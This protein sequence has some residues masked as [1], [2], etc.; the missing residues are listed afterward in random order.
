MKTA[1]CP[2]SVRLAVA[3]DALND[4]GHF[5]RSAE[6]YAAACAAAAQ[7]LVSE[8]C[9]IVTFLR[10]WQARSIVCHGAVPTLS[11]AERNQALQDSRELLPPCISTLVRCKEAGTLLPGSCRAAEMAWS[12]AFHQHLPLCDISIAEAHARADAFAVMIGYE[13]YL[14]AASTSLDAMLVHTK[15]PQQMLFASFV[16]SALDLLASQP[17]QPAV[18][19]MG[20]V[21][22]NHE[23]T[24]A[25]NV[26]R[27]F[28]FGAFTSHL[29]AAAAELLTDAWR[30]LERSG[31]LEQRLLGRDKL[32]VDP[33]QSVTAYLAAAEAEGAARG[34]HT[35]ALAGCAAKEVHVSQFKKCGACRTV[36]YCCKEHQ[37]ADWPAH[38]AAC[39]AAARHAR[40]QRNRETNQP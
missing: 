4:K 38:K 26:R 20:R 30:R 15:G 32:P 40:L 17:R 22:A 34:L 33:E 37:V 27:Y 36:A 28:E 12:R 7:E 14:F 18:V 19:A 13:A 5:A 10:V 23:L 2:V 1:D 16:A 8:D 21:V 11:A 35:C 31:V 3:A 29:V 6:K 9:L 24:L 25:K 39:K